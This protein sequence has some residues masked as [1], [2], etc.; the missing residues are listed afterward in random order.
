MKY[1][2]EQLRILREIRLSGFDKSETYDDVYTNAHDEFS[3]VSEMF[4]DWILK[5]ESNG[6]I[7]YLIDNYK[8]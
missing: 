3:I 5:M 1:S 4:L 2:L 8:P 6:K 7:Q